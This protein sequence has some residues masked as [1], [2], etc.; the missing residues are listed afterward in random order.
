MKKLLISLA[1]LTAFCVTAQES[2]DDRSGHPTIVNIYNFIRSSVHSD[3]QLHEDSFQTVVNQIET[4]KQYSLP[5][6]YAIAHD[7]L[8]EP[9][10]QALLKD[11][12]EPY[13]EIACWW[14][15]TEAL[16]RRAGVAW[17]KGPNSMGFSRYSLGYSPSD[18]IKLVDAYMA[19]F[20]SVFGYYPKSAGSWVI[21]IVTIKYMKEKYGIEAIATCRD[22]IGVDGFT[23]WGGYFN[24]IY[25]PSTVNEYIPAQTAEYQ[26]DIPVVR[27]LGPDPIYNFE[28]FRG[29]FKGVLSMEPV[30]FTGQD[31]RWVEWYFNTLAQPATIAYG[32]V[33]VGQ[34]NTFLWANMENGYE[35][36]MPYVAKLHAEG[37]IR[38]ENI[39]ATARWFR[40]KYALTPAASF[41]VTEDWNDTHNLVTPWYYSRYYR[42]S[43]LAEQNR[44][45]IRD[46]FIFDQKYPSKYLTA[47][48]NGHESQMNAL[49]VMD[50][51][52]WGRDLTTVRITD[53]NRALI[54]II[55][56]ATGSDI[57]AD[58]D[59]NRISYQK[60]DGQTLG[61]SW[62][63]ADT[64]F[65]FVCSESTMS[66]NYGRPW[67][68]KITH[69][70]T[71]KSVDG[72]SVT[73]RFD[74]FD[75][76]LWCDLGSVSMNAD[77][78]ILLM[79]D[80]GGLKLRFTNSGQGSESV[81]TSAYM[82]DPQ[83]IDNTTAAIYRTSGNVAIR[84]KKPE[85]IPGNT[86]IYKP[87]SVTFEINNPNPDGEIHYTID[88]SEPTS[89]SPR[90]R[91]PITVSD[92]AHLQSVVCADGKLPS[93]IKS[94]TVYPTIRIE[95]IDGLT[96]FAGRYN[97]QGYSDLIDGVKA[98]ITYTDGKWTGFMNDLEAVLDLGKSQDISSVTMSFLQNIPAWIFFPKTLKCEVSDDGKNFREV[99]TT[100]A[101]DIH[102]TPQEVAIR[103]YTC[104]FPTVKTRYIRLKAESIKAG[105]AP[106]W[107]AGVGDHGGYMFADEITV[108]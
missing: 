97:R 30:W 35:I 83:S 3:G 58:S 40:S 70:P 54:R 44:L 63:V 53:P 15:I 81:Y 101:L 1:A 8:I 25:Y 98:S 45:A 12:L 46:L 7:A 42:V 34:E 105:E 55:D 26:L 78:S 71:V 72:K 29:G 48:V 60:I 17:Q 100:P 90:Y 75:Y 102:A 33:Q 38:L 106:E 23:L 84:A 50:G 4:L 96:P 21:D 77:S 92:A 6:T 22:Q 18:R 2:K 36:Q 67:A 80:S 73:F 85:I 107:C 47:T 57:V 27:L 61:V 95:S 69:T 82:S 68:M 37:K 79:P 86:L 11:N 16:A 24:G 43:L 31:P 87:N 52:R 59:K 104:T 89:S 76:I 62:S 28:D 88:G 108:N 99:A 14:E 13:D 74:D 65:E 5:S 103:D 64:G 32:Y 20:K 51:K 94:A 9:R 66:V 19:D 49:P 91:S 93:R 41:N 56:P 39:S 10:Y